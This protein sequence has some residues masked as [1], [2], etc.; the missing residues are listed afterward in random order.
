MLYITYSMMHRLLDTNSYTKWANI[1][2]NKAGERLLE[3]LSWGVNM[4]E[5]FVLFLGRE[6]L[7]TTLLAA[8]PMLAAALFTGLIVAVFQATTQIQE[9]TLAFVPK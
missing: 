3:K 4:T 1:L 2:I 8:A 6:A 9:Q 7:F 5:E